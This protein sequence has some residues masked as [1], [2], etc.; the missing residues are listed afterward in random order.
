MNSSTKRTTRTNPLQYNSKTGD[1]F[2]ELR[3]SGMKIILT[4]ARFEDASAL[5]KYLNDPRVFEGLASPPN[6]YLPEHATS[7]LKHLGEI[8]TK[9]LE[10]TKLAETDETTM[11]DGCPVGIIREVKED[12]T[13][14]LIG[15]ID[16]HRHGWMY[17]MDE[18][19]R[20]E[21][22]K[23]ETSKPVG[24]PTICWELGGEI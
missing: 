1:P 11:V 3:V 6:P 15:N 20:E 17:I 8:H 16:F 10:Q 2:M 22:R 13:E 5:I 18:K 9:L 24:D 19:R 21:L 4:P 23:V 14:E 7:W 12:G